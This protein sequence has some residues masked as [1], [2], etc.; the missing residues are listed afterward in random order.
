VFHFF[1]C[2]VSAKNQFITSLETILK[3]GHYPICDFGDL[4]CLFFIVVFLFLALGFGMSLILGDCRNFTGQLEYDY[5]FSSPPDFD[6]IGFDPNDRGQYQTFI[7]ECFNGAFEKKVP[8][9]FALTDR[10]YKSGVIS[11]S[12]LLMNVM[13]LYGYTLAS[14]KI[15]AKAIDTEWMMRLTYSNV[16]TF[17]PANKKGNPVSS[18]KVNRDYKPFRPDVWSIARDAYKGYGYAI[19]VELVKRCLMA[20]LRSGQRVYDP[21]MGSGTT[22]VAAIQCGFD[23]VGTEI[24]ETTFQL[25][26]QRL[27]DLKTS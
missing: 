14:H 2:S 18:F 10:K 20:H 13:R 12:N 27:K 8:I 15:W 5:I 22:A 25:S 17:A 6:E 1:S 3:T 7:K 11:K 4:S 26:Q 24:D 9:T 19:P 16:M 23:F 21:F